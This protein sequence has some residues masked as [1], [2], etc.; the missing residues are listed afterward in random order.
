VANIEHPTLA[1]LF[2]N[3]VSNWCGLFIRPS[4]LFDLYSAHFPAFGKNLNELIEWMENSIRFPQLRKC[5][6][7]RQRSGR[8][9]VLNWRPFLRCGVWFCGSNG[10]SRMTTA[11]KMKP[12]KRPRCHRRCVATNSL[13]LSF[14]IFILGSP[15]PPH[16]TH[17]APHSCESFW[18]PFNPFSMPTSLWV[19]LPRL[20][21]PC[22]LPLSSYTYSLFLPFTRGYLHF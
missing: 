13:A 7:A 6:K 5:G 21:T 3:F 20:D 17:S 8:C 10:G 15:L 2:T 19:Y 12:T 22:N 1:W 11:T 16:H 9:W 14:S 18:L 4:P